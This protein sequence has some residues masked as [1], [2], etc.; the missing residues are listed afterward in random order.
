MSHAAFLRAILD[1]PDDDAP[2][3][4]YADWLDDRGDADRAELIR[5]Q[6]EIA[7]P[8]PCRI[9]D[10]CVYGP[11][12][13]P[14]R[15]GELIWFCGSLECA[16]R[17]VFRDRSATLFDRLGLADARAVAFGLPKWCY[18]SDDIG[19]VCGP[20]RASAALRRGFVHAVTI[21]WPDCR[22]HLDAIL[23]AQP[24][25]TVRLASTPI[26]GQKRRGPDSHYFLASTRSEDMRV[27]M[28]WPDPDGFPPLEKLL[29]ARWPYVKEWHLPAAIS[30]RGSVRIGDRT[31]DSVS[32]SIVADQ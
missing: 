19:S 25:R 4:V 14:E 5:V 30:G 23:A 9:P 32:W 1:R 22:D 6:C 26:P 16:K 3:L 13:R 17:A 15:E 31:F 18:V 24:V 28:P 29:S 27:P 10:R 21:S 8:E 20:W 7:K 12:P 2:R 11:N